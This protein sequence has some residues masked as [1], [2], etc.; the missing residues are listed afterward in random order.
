M[1]WVRE[2]TQTKLFDFEEIS[3]VD[4]ITVLLD[5]MLYEDDQLVNMVLDLLNTH[6]S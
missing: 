6:F 4:Y 5:L 2:F 1:D 3:E